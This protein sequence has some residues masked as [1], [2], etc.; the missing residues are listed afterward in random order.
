MSSVIR[1]FHRLERGLLEIHHGCRL[2]DRTYALDS[3][4][5]TT[6]RIVSTAAAAVSSLVV[7]ALFRKPLTLGCI[8]AH[9][10]SSETRVRCLIEREEVLNAGHI[11]CGGVK[12]CTASSYTIQGLC[13]QTS[14]VRQN[15]HELWFEFTSDETIKGHCSCK[16]GNSVICKHM[17]A[18]LLFTHR[19][20]IHNMDQLTSTDV[21]QAWGKLK[22]KNIYKAKKKNQGFMP[23]TLNTKGPP[24]PRETLHNSTEAD[25]CCSA[26]RL[27]KACG[28]PLPSEFKHGRKC[29]PVQ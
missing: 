18:M 15:P 10:G 21:K 27:G 23:R 1:N 22:A 13:L 26:E 6:N 24:G 20:G 11:I 4:S 7:M 19:I 3:V 9:I 12:E 25:C 14:Q 8:M 29:K 5:V 16:A 2:G 28:E 17:I